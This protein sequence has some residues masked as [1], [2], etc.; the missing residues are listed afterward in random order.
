MLPP[1]A[2]PSLGL[3]VGGGAAAPARVA[4]TCAAALP[5]A[6]VTRVDDMEESTARHE[7]SGV[8]GGIGRGAASGPAPASLGSGAA[9]AAV[10]LDEHRKK[11]DV[12]RKRMHKVGA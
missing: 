6:A 3:G 1:T 11:S 10:L 7:G 8:A 12:T 4:P 5:Q 9:R 2:E